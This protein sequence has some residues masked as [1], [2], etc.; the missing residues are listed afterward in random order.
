MSFMTVCLQYQSVYVKREVKA[1]STRMQLLAA[2]VLLG[3]FAVR[4]W[5]KLEATDI[6]YQVA[7]QRQQMVKLDMERRELE[8]QR[9]LLLRPDSL[10]RSARDRVGLSD[11]SLDQTITVTY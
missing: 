7:R 11:H 9:S 2:V 8:L 6:G 3:V 10:A 4:V 1:S 5:A